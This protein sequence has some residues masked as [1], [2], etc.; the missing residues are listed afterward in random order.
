MTTEAITLRDYFAAQVAGAYLTK[1]SDMDIVMSGMEF[2]DF[3]AVNAY[4]MAD[5]L[6]KE[7]NQG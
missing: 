4:M 1:F 5:A 6:L 2:E 3:V 7:R